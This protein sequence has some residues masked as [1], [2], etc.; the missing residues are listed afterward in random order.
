MPADLSQID[1]GPKM[2][3]CSERER[4]FVWH[5]CLNGGNGAQAARD[6]GYSDVKEGAKVRA[7][8]LMQ[9]E[10]VLDALDEVGRK[11]FRS[12][13]V[14]AITAMRALVDRPDHPD[15]AKTVGSVLDRLGLGGRTA[16]DV[17]VNGTVTVNHTDAA[18]EDLRILKAMGVA[19]EKLVE[20]FGYSGLERYERMLAEKQ[21]KLIEGEVIRD[22]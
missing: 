4:Q 6:A 8:S 21:P 2:A 22:G 17:N 13:L 1:F 19:R 10:R 3:A 15:H 16:V 11:Q 9:R 18:I 7:H 12:L 5:Y 14:P 20:T